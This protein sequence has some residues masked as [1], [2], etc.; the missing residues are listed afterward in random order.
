MTLLFG[1]R[2]L[3]SAGLVVLTSDLSNRLRDAVEHIDKDLSALVF[4]L[5]CFIWGGGWY[6]CFVRTWR[7]GHL[8]FVVES[9]IRSTFPAS[10]VCGSS[11][12]FPVSAC[13]AGEGC[14]CC[15]WDQRGRGGRIEWW[16]SVFVVSGFYGCV[17]LMEERGGRERVGAG[18]RTQKDCM[19]SPIYINLTLM[20]FNPCFPNLMILI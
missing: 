19:I 15:D 10:C 6:V 2:T 11:F 17:D 13:V 9:H 14:G 1:G 4:G 5:W 18:S 16:P 3:C 12:C 20:F 8:S 7:E